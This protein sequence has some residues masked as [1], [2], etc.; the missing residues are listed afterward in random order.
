MTQGSRSPDPSFYG[1]PRHVWVF[2]AL[3]L[4]I[5]LLPYVTTL[6]YGFV[7]DDRLAIEENSHVRA[8]PGLG[9]IFLSDVWTLSSL[10]TR[11][12]YYRPMFLLAYFGIF[13]VAGAAPAVFH[14]VNILF[15]AAATGMVFVL[16]LRFWR[17]EFT[18][19]IAAALFALHPTHV[20]PVAWIAALSELVYTF[21]VLLAVYFYTSQPISRGLTAVALSSY[22]M[23]LL[24]KESAVAFIPIA[25]LYDLLVLRQRRWT[26]WMTIMAVTLAYVGLRVTAMGAL[27]PSILHPNLSLATQVLTAISNVGFYASKL[28]VPIRL[29]AFYP[30]QFIS[31][32][33]LAVIVVLLLVL[34]SIWT[35]RDHQAWAASW[36]LA[37]LFPVLLVSRI[38]VPLAD[39]NLYL[40]SVGFVWLAASWMDRLSRKSSFALLLVIT[41]AYGT[42]TLRRLPAWRDDMA[43]LGHELR[44]NPDS[45]QVRLLLAS[46]LARQGEL[47]PALLEVDEILRRHPDDPEALLNKAGLLSTMQDWAG[48]RSTCTKVFARDPASPRC[49]MNVGF[50]DEHEGRLTDAHEK[51]ARAFRGDSSLSQALLH[52]GIVEAR[53]GRLPEAVRTLE[54]AVERNPTAGALTNLGSVYANT[55][56]MQKAVQVF[57][58]AVVVDPSFQPA[59]QNLERALAETR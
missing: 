41:G 29:S 9:R 43:L 57:Q 51:F 37:S 6:T 11:S 19:F 23:A 42:L 54:F 28:L 40:A 4:A 17:K 30:T 2:L 31:G 12:N 21:F 53:M 59:R 58:K 5:A 44:M 16:S 47:P 38:A 50:I 22:A 13:Q 33:A 14:L 32:P 1:Q 18:A 45:V 55:G 3:S 34:L 27:S 48:V 52:Q 56:E 35:L 46:E 36:I 39:R 8:W 24:W 15:H 25:V 26:R 20:E 7:Y 49:L 10:S